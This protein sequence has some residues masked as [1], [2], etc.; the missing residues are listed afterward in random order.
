[1]KRGVYSG[2]ENEI[3]S[4]FQGVAI[5]DIRKNRDVILYK[6]D[7]IV[8]KLRIPDHKNRLSKSNGFRLLYLVYN[9]FEDVVLLDIYPKRGPMQKLDLSKE[10]Y[11]NLYHTFD[12]EDAD[13]SLIPYEIE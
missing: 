11:L 10:E 7:A 8:I 3:R 13:N 5:E 9:E 6:D 12:Q 2:V 4:A 1:M